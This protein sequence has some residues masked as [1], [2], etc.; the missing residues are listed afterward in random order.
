MSLLRTLAALSWLIWGVLHLWVGQNG[1]VTWVAGPKV[2]WESLVGGDKV[3]HAAFVHT[4]DPATAF[5][6]SQLIFNFTNDVGGY[7]VLG[8]FIA[9]AIFFKSP[10]DHFA[11]WVGVIILGIADLS[12]LFI[13]VVGGVIH[14][15]FEVVLG[16]A[17]WFVAVVLTPFA[18]DWSPKKTKTT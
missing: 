18:L 13:M 7:G 6:H 3:P 9:F 4:K 16:P 15:S 2:Q 11:Y 17:I 10:A 14:A 1:Y 12:F 5:A 8:V